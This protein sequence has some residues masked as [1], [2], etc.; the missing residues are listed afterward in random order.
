M[1]SVRQLV[2]PAAPEDGSL[3]D[4][5]HALCTELAAKYHVT[6]AQILLRYHLDR[7][8]T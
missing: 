6:P 5:G 7:G 1:P 8:Q 3:Y 2:A 4:K